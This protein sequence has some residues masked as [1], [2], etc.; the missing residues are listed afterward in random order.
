[1]S[2]V[3]SSFFCKA[4]CPQRSVNIPIQRIPRIQTW[5]ESTRRT[6]GLELAD[7]LA[8]LV[9]L[10]ADL[11]EVELRCGEDNRASV[12]PRIREGL[13]EGRGGRGGLTL[14]PGL[15]EGDDLVDELDGLAAFALRFADELGVAAPV[16][17][18]EVDVQHL[19]AR[20]RIGVAAAAAAAAAERKKGFLGVTIEGAFLF[21][22]LFI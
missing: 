16:R 14:A 1:M 21:F 22:R 11:V 8:G 6:Y 19:G 3:A 15:V 7:L 20:R 4:T 5:T 10:L 12:R 2:S 17:A 13:G 9:E 18:E